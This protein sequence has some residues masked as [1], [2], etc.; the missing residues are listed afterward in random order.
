MGQQQHG[1]Q[2]AQH[3][4]AQLPLRGEECATAAQEEDAGGARGGGARE[5]RNQTAGQGVASR[6]GLAGHVIGLTRSC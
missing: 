6:G 5:G 2:D 4:Q 1:M 3:P